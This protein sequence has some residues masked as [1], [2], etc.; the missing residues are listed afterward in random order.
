M[1]E[2]SR[3]RCFPRYPCEGAAEILQDGKHCAWGKVSDI[4]R[5]GCYLETVHP[6]PA[7][8]EV[9]LHLTI[10]GNVL[11]LDA[12]VAWVTPQI[13]MG[14][15]FAALAPE[16]ESKLANILEELT[17]AAHPPVAPPVERPVE[18]PQPSGSSLRIRRESAPE[19]LGQV[20]KWINEK[21]VLTK[22]EMVEIVRAATR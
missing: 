22:Q 12:R 15:Y 21:G 16:A 17:A 4:S 14:M 18:R 9:Q 11:E 10:A 5:C 20:V 2:D 1:E 19:I 7:G 13:G 8:I 3:R 6:F